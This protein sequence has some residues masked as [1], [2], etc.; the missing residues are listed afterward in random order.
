MIRICTL[1]GRLAAAMLLIL[2]V[3]MG[4][5]SVLDRIEQKRSV[6]AE[7]EPVQD[8]VV[9]AGFFLPALFL[10]W[11][12]SWWSLRPLARVSQDASNVGPANPALRLSSAGLPTEIVPLVQAVNAAL[13]RMALAFEAERRFTE[14]AAH[15]LRTPL[16]VLGLRLQRARQ[17]GAGSQGPDWDAIDGDLLQM[18]R[19]VI[20]LL[21][22][23]GCSVIILMLS[24]LFLRLLGD[25]GVN[26]LE[27]L[28]GLLLVML[29][30]QMFLDG[31]RTYLRG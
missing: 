15:E 22:A 27:R 5:A 7:E 12:V 24:T 16:A 28:M 19:L 8:A 9:L 23:W 1:R 13:D 14:N 11:A 25:K 3:S 2:F 6:P 20:A 31:V 10:I 30:T 18:N 17:S 29:S 4:V 26:A 21:I